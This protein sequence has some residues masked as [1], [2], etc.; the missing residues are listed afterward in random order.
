MQEL[1]E[2]MVEWQVSSRGV[3]SRRVLD[4]LGS[5]GNLSRRSVGS[6]RPTRAWWARPTGGPRPGTG[7]AQQP[8]LPDVRTAAARQRP[9]A[10]SLT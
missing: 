4:A 9:L 6:V 1:R 3:R 8:G 5:V 10:G 2:R 7:R